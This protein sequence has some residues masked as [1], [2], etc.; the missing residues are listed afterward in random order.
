MAKLEGDD[1]TVAGRWG[2]DLDFAQRSAAAGIDDC[3][4][5][6]IRQGLSIPSSTSMLPSRPMG[7]SSHAVPPAEVIPSFAEWCHQRLGVVWPEARARAYYETKRTAGEDVG[8]VRPQ[9]PPSLS[10]GPAPGTD[11]QRSVGVPQLDRMMDH[12]DA[13]D[14]AE[15]AKNGGRW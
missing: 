4:R 3:M 1:Q 6:I 12:Q 5:G 9:S 2:Q 7:T 10:S 11:W 8:P 15:R 14:R 13:L